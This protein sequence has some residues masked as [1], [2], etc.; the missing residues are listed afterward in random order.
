MQLVSPQIDYY[1]YSRV[2]SKLLELTQKHHITWYRSAMPII[3]S[4][5]LAFGDVYATHYAG[6]RVFICASSGSDRAVS[7][8]LVTIVFN[9]GG[10][11]SYSLQGLS[12]LSSLFQAVYEQVNPQAG[13]EDIL[14]KIISS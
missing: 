14:D 6:T 3:S 1:K 7:D 11:R 4:G 10:D 13:L 2:I 9:D 8:A 12:G 5:P